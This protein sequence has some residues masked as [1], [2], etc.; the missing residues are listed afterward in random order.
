MR[1][2]GVIQALIRERHP[3]AVLAAF[4]ILMPVLFSAAGAGTRLASFR[5]GDGTVVICTGDGF[6]RISDPAAV[7]DGGLPHERADCCATGCVHSGGMGI[8]PAGI[9]SA[10]LPFVFAG[11]LRAPASRP[12][13]AAAHAAPGAIRAPPA[14]PV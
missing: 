12:V 14:K 2:S 6:A 9:A 1:P 5:L 13:H 8:A 11:H 10:G 3:F 4:A 7:P